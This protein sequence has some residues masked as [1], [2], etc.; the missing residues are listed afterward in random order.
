MNFSLCSRL[1]KEAEL[2]N[3]SK[4]IINQGFCTQMFSTLGKIR[5]IMPQ[6]HKIGKSWISCSQC[7]YIFLT[8]NY[9]I[10]MG[11]NVTSKKLF[12]KNTVRIGTSGLWWFCGAFF[13][14]YYFIAFPFC[15]IYTYAN[16]YK[17]ENNDFLFCDT[18]CLLHCDFLLIYNEASGGKILNIHESYE[19]LKDFEASYSCF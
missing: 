16:G 19:K 1:K 4:S 7:N 13:F 5:A 18:E 15:T 2:G 11:L 17:T 10:M 12:V 9:W 6:I 3:P 8:F 14:Y